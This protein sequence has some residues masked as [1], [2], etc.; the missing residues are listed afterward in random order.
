[1]DISKEH[2]RFLKSPR[3]T[4]DL[5]VNSRGYKQDAFCGQIAKSI[6]PLTTLSILIASRVAVNSEQEASCKLQGILVH[7]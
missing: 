2:P 3:E 5:A 4:F 7:L 1:M 6:D